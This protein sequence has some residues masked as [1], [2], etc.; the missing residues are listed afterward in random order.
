MRTDSATGNSRRVRPVLS[1]VIG[2][3]NRRRLLRQALDSVR[4]ELSGIRHEILVVDGGSTDG[5]INWLVKQR[6]VIT[7]VQHNRG[8]VSGKPV[9][10]KSWGYFMNLAFKAAHGKYVCMLSDDC[11]VVPGAITNGLQLFDRELKQGR[12]IGAIAFYFRDWP[13]DPEYKIGRTWGDRMYVNHGL[14]LREALADV[15][16]VDEDSYRF[17]HADGD[18]ALRMWDAGYT[19]VDSK[20]SYI[21]HYPHATRGVRASN[22]A[23]QKKDWVRYVARWGSLGEPTEGWIKRA[24]EDPHQTARTHW[25][26]QWRV[27]RWRTAF[28]RRFQRPAVPDLE[29]LRSTLIDDRAVTLVVDVGAND[30][31]FAMDLRG[32]GY[33][34]RIA[35]FEPLA[36]AYAEL[37]ARSMKDDRWETFQV[38]LGAEPQTAALNVAGN[39][40]SSSLLPMNERHRKAEPRSAYVGTEA[41]EVVTLDQ[42]AHQVIASE[43]R[44]CLKIDVQ[45]TE[46]SV[47]RGAEHVLDQVEVIQVE[48]SLVP[49]Y[50]GA[51][52]LDEVVSFLDERGFG[53][54]GFA[55]AF[56]DPITEAILQVDGIFAR[57]RD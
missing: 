54:L 31:T 7:I 56:A 42:I 21:E 15:G 23:E 49:L 38:A 35:S 12:R 44:V 53:L 41:C 3:F 50:D 46:L 2:S 43:D 8:E 20:D 18:L 28:M 1:I 26:W 29:R 9:Q 24:Y 30:G 19:C 45:G 22:M 57:I 6:D 4:R 37:A 52:S 5:T 10:R 34:G 27:M 40:V 32:G 13:I 48:A 11:L 25:L 33:A 14:F 51:P 47:L 36:R 17:Y 55:S 16:Y 39:S